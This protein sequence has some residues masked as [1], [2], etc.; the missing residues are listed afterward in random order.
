MNLDYLDYLEYEEPVFSQGWIHEDDIPDMQYSK[1]MIISIINAIYETGDVSHLTDCLRVLADEFELR[2][3]NK[4]AL[5]TKGR[6][7]EREAYPRY[8]GY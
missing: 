7:H 5:I 1:D 8:R 6:E 4:K 2:L 3:P